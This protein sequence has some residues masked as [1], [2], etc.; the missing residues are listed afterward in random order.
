MQGG[1][2]REQVRERLRT[3]ARRAISH[4]SSRWVVLAGTV[5]I[6]CGGAG[7]LLQAGADLLGL[8]LL[9]HLGHLSPLIA[10]SHPE[11]HAVHLA[12][13]IPAWLRVLPILTIGGIGAGWLAL[14][15]A[16][17]AKGGGT[18]HA[19]I[20]YH[21][22]RGSIGLSVPLTKIAA[23]ILTLGSG[24]SGGREGPIALVGAGFGS[25]FATRVGLTTRD[26][27]IL[28]IAGIAGGIAAVFRAPLAAAIFG[29]EVLYRGTDLEA[30][31]LIPAFIASII[32]YCV[33][34]QLDGLWCAATHAFT[35]YGSTL[36]EPPANLGFAVADWPQLI[37]Y[38]I[39]ALAIV[40][41]ARLF[42]A[43][44]HAVTDLAEGSGR[45]VWLTAGAGALAAGIITVALTMGARFILPAPLVALVPATLGSGYGPL[46]WALHGG[47]EQ[48]GW[49][50]PVVFA[51]IALGK[52]LTT[53]CTVASGGSGGMFGPAIAIGGAVGAAVGL[54]MAGLAIAPPPAAALLLGMAGLLAATH[55][56]P[57]AAML[58]VAEISG[59]YLLLIPSMWVVG[60]SFLLMRGNSILSGQVEHLHDS[61]AHRLI[62]GDIFASVHVADLLPRLVAPT[63]AP[64]TTTLGRC[65]TLLLETKQPMLPITDTDGRLLGVVTTDDLRA[66]SD[67][68]LDHLV[69]AGDCAHGAAAAVQSDDSLRRVLRRLIDQRLEAVVVVDE[70]RRPLGLVTRVQLL[71]TYQQEIERLHAERRAEGYAVPLSSRRTTVLDVLPGSGEGEG[72]A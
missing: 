44:T 25:W 49:S 41:V 60:L 17:E 56:T 5:G 9:E 8:F 12:P 26:R 20:A 62:G 72:P 58:M 31:A 40:A 68:I 52:T 11:A 34:G 51:I 50:V 22:H 48:V 23:S 21:Q 46:H 29:C 67:P 45:P 32:G 1:P 57:I 47:L 15:F 27:R 53:A 55:R 30:D 66:S 64:A 6:I 71:D 19:I 69:L 14:R 43:A 35:P 10:A 61:P 33:S 63:C 3:L 38:T 65:R 2:W 13:V 59:S 28:L 54:A 36:F 16:P 39:L 37:G 42:I 7:F 18:S 70:A 24:G 4:E